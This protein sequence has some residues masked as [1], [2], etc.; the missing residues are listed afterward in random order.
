MF[1]YIDKPNNLLKIPYGVTVFKDKE[2][3]KSLHLNGYGYYS[4]LVDG[5]YVYTTAKKLGLLTQYY[6]VRDLAQC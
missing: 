5:R 2:G 3:W 6:L 4:S 1:T